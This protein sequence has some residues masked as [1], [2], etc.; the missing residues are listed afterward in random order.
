MGIFKGHNSRSVSISQEMATSE[1]VS[2]LKIQ[3]YAEIGV[4]RK[5]ENA[6]LVAKELPPGSQ[7]HLFDYSGNIKAIKTLM[8]GFD[9]DISYYGH[10]YKNRDSYCW[11]LTKLL[12]ESETPEGQA[13]L[14]DYVRLNGMCDLTVDGLA[15]YLCDK[16]LSEKGYIE[17]T[18]YDWTYMSSPSMNPSVRE[19]T[20]QD[21]TN[22]MC[23]V[24]HIQMVV[25][26]LV[27]SDPRYTAILNDR[28][29]RKRPFITRRIGRG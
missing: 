6:L 9:L 5:A 26:G 11:S 29:Y 25:D 10:S 27:K 19:K 23:E 3:S 28:L 8:E 14:F 7:M 4:G 17:F 22:A 1:L 13:N 21:Y 2:A 18:K 15:F 16:L 24:P 12:L 20:K